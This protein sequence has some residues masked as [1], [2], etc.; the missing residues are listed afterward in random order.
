[1][2]PIRAWLGVDKDGRA[3]LFPERPK[4][5]KHFGE[6]QPKSRY[7]G[8]FRCGKMPDLA[9]QCLEVYVLPKKPKRSASRPSSEPQVEWWDNKK[10]T[11]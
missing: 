3:F 4:Y 11:P 8:Y 5:D 10:E 9:G 2:K 6:W 7:G 1:M